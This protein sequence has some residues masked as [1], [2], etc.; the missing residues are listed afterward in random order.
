MFCTSNDACADGEECYGDWLTPP[1]CISV[2]ARDFFKVK[3]PQGDSGGNDSSS[4]VSDTGCVDATALRHFQHQQLTLDKH[5]R[6]KV[7]C[8]SFGSCATPGHMVMS[9]GKA[10]MM[11]SYCGLVE[12]TSEVM[13]VNSPRWDR[14][15]RVKSKTE[16]LEYTAFAARWESK[17]EEHV[18]R[19]AVRVGM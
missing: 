13:L 18:L 8:D 4:R 19:T 12:C 17:A 9:E 2:I 10:M 1:R 11:R 3:E 16:A 15:L 7:F 6:A 5:I 14:A